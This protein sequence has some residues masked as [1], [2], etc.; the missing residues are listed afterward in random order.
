[1]IWFI[2]R[3]IYPC[4]NLLYLS[5]LNLKIWR[6]NYYH[7]PTWCL[8]NLTKK[9]TAKTFQRII[10]RG[11]TLHNIICTRLVALFIES[12]ILRYRKLYNMTSELFSFF[13]SSTIVFRDC[14]EN[15]HF[16]RKW[17]W[18]CVN[19][20]ARARFVMRWKYV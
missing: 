13:F 6:L 19:P 10:T 4:T 3:T 17:N 18:I 9:H 15:R 5:C 8:G 16:S 1:M 2:I 20:D 12:I 11:I 7:G 14:S